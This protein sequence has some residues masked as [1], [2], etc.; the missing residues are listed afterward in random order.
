M[1]STKDLRTI[2]RVDSENSARRATKLP[3]IKKSGKEK[4]YLYGD[5]DDEEDLDADYKQRESVL[6]YYDDEEE[7]F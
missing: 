4:H 2:N 3:P 6:D 5:L 7:D 1:K